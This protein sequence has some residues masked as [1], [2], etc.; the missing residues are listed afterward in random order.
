MFDHLSIFPNP[1]TS[2]NQVNISYRS[3]ESFSGTLAIMDITGKVLVNQQL[4]V[5]AGTA[6]IPVNMPAVAQGIYF[7]KISDNTKSEL[8]QFIV[9]D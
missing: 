7:I 6:T 4:N 3:S 9:T 1:V 8:V 5:I 2:G